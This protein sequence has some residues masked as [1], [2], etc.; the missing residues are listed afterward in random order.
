MDRFAEISLKPFVPRLTARSALSPEEREAVLSLPTRR[1]DLHPR[2]NF[3]H[4]N[5]EASYSCYVASGLVGRFA[6]D[7]EGLRQITA[8]HIPGDVADLHFVV[9]PLG[10]SGLTALS[11]AVILRIPDVAIRQ[12]AT[13]Y[14]ALAEAFWRDC[15]LDAAVLHAMGCERRQ[16]RCA[17]I[18]C[19]MSI[20]YGE[21]REVLPRY[22]SPATQDQ[23]A[24]ACGLTSVH[25]N[26][27]LK[28]LR[29][30][31]LVTIRRS[32]VEI[33]DREQLASA[34]LLACLCGSA[35]QAAD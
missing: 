31:G 11:T 26:R 19:E 27:S 13:G 15:M 2:Q 12:L 6:Q 9:R 4:I 14:P 35:P 8:F 7:A 22:E 28:I 20:R 17:H 21:D 23:L 24:D 33:H 5:E 30:E 3:V 25:V 16:A 1:I 10:I 29:N 34:G 32:A 18:L